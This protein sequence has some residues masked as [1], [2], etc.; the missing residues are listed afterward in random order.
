LDG[1]FA[2]N[3]RDTC[4]VRNRPPA[5]VGVLTNDHGKKVTVVILCR[6]RVA[7]APINQIS[8]VAGGCNTPVTI[9]KP[10]CRCRSLLLQQPGYLGEFQVEFSPGISPG[11]S[12]VAGA[13]SCNGILLLD[14]ASHQIRTVC[15]CNIRL[16]KR[17]LKMVA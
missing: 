4:H 8:I 16:T 15:S 6:G 11:I 7:S 1:V 5:V 10:A 14:E 17:S 13:N 12:L 3:H 9:E 2:A